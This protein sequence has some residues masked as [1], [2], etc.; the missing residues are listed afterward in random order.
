LPPNC[1]TSAETIELRINS[2]DLM[3]IGRI[4]PRSR[5][6][7][8]AT[9]LV[10]DEFME[11]KENLKEELAAAKEEIKI[12]ADKILVLEKRVVSLEERVN[13][14]EEDSATSY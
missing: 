3:F 1:P 14:S 11:K 12:L 9:R 7:R 8:T 13:Q 10:Y 6:L 2:L 4:I 5:S